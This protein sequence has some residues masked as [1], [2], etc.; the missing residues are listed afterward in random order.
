MLKHRLIL[1]IFYLSTLGA[2]FNFD[3]ASL[4]AEPLDAI[5]A[6]V[7]ADP[8]T[9]SDLNE[10]IKPLP[11]VKISELKTNAIAQKALDGL[12]AERLLQAEAETNR[13]SVSEADVNTYVQEVA[14]KNGLELPAFKEAL[15]QEGKNF[16]Q[17]KRQVRFEILKTR[18]A[19]SIM[20]QGGGVTDQ[21]IAN[22][23]QEN[24]NSPS[25]ENKIHLQQIV[26]FKEEHSQGEATQIL[27]KIKNEADSDESFS[28]AAKKFSESP[29]ASEGG[30]LGEVIEKDLN[31]TIFSAVLTLEDGEISEIVET[32]LGYHLLRVISRSGTEKNREQL[33]ETVRKQL[34]RKKLE[35]RFQAYFTNEIY[36]NHTV[37]KKFE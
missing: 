28:A 31:P 26:L 32:E 20:E 12:I 30:D 35:E 16:D 36:K 10:M 7:D 11:P 14:K 4:S 34:D 33:E 9:L 15:L 1:S 6:T 8:I 2:A 3:S 23:I 37:E 24:Y 5:V 29:D 19:G 21:E 27:T 13:V 17:Y 22:Y 25:A 18:L